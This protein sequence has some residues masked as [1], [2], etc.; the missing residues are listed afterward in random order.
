MKKIA[1]DTQGTGRFVS[2]VSHNLLLEEF[3]DD[4]HLTSAG[5]LTVAS[6]FV[7]AAIPFIQQRYLEVESG[8]PICQK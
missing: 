2:Y 6:D 5:N 8:K 3:L 1:A 4:A 7:K